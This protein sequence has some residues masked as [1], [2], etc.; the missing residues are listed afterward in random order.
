M[1]VVR[2]RN[3]DRTEPVYAMNAQHFIDDSLI[4]RRVSEDISQQRRSGKVRVE[5]KLIRA[6]VKQ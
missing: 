2:M 3:K 6:I 5:Q 1:I 4:R